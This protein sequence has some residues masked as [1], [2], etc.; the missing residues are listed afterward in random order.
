MIQFLKQYE[1]VFYY[2]SMA[3]FLSICIEEIKNIVKK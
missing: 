2:L 1:A 3:A